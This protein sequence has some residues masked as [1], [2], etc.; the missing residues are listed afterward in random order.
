MNVCVN[1]CSCGRIHLIPNNKIT[2]AI[3]TNRDLVII[4]AGCGAAILTGADPEPDWEGTGEACYTLY[5]KGYSVGGTSSITTNRFTSSY[6]KSISE[7]FYSQGVKVPMKT[8]MYARYFN[9][10]AGFLDT[11]RPDF[12]DIK[13]SD[14]TTE[15]LLAFIHKYEEDSSTVD[16]ER[17]IIENSKDVIDTLRSHGITGLDWSNC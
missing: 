9:S 11:Y 17:L 1:V 10:C 4:C 12:S 7:I 13:R 14:I 8:G 15:E 6:C 5:T 2:A 16:M 3:E